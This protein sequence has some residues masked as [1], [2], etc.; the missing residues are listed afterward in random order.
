LRSRTG[1]GLITA[2]VFASIA[3]F[4]D[5]SVVNVAIP[6]IGRDLGAGVASR[7]A[8]PPLP[9]R[10]PVAGGCPM[11]HIGCRVTVVGDNGRRP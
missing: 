1:A 2:T 3:G 7:P 10:W 5:A 4:P 11:R 9:G 6:A 8:A